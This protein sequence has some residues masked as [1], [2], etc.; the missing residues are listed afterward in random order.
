M[1]DRFRRDRGFSQP[2]QCFPALIVFPGP[3]MSDGTT[4]SS[5]AWAAYWAGADPAGG[6]AVRGELQARLLSGYWADIFR[7]AFQRRPHCRILDAA[8]GVGVVTRM[9]LDV[10]GSIAGCT[11]EVHCTD[12]ALPAVR[13]IRESLGAAVC[14]ETSAD[15]A[16]LPYKNDVFDLVVSQFGLEYAGAEAFAEAARVTRGDGEFHALVHKTQGAIYAECR[17]NL[18]V[19]QAIETSDLLGRFDAA[20]AVF[21]KIDKGRASAKAGERKQMDFMRALES[22]YA[23]IAAR[24][25][26]SAR[27]H[28]ERLVGDVRQLLSRRAAYAPQDI[29]GWVAGQRRDLTAF[30]LRMRSMLDAA[31]DETDLAGIGEGMRAAGLTQVATSELVLDQGSRAAAWIVSARSV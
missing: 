9:G 1:F 2:L 23:D 17:E 3:E 28:G 27:A 5:D 30:S 22:L 24:P 7:D 19:L 16:R 10:A 4:A 14:G 26:G 21:R 12:Y 29:D 6:D 20:L 31:V 11:L 8:C 15:A 18:S 25:Q 13:G